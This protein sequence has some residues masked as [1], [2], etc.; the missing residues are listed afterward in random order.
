MSGWVFARSR[1]TLPGDCP[2]DAMRPH[3]RRED[4]WI[5]VLSRSFAEHRVRPLACGGTQASEQAGLGWLGALVDASPAVLTL[6]LA[7][8]GAAADLTVPAL[9]AAIAGSGPR[10]VIATG[11]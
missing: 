10:F 11:A 8:S 6:D 5:S 1:Y 9:R 2:P 3:G 4:R 7:P